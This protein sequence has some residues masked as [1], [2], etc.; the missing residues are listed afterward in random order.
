MA[1]ITEVRIKNFVNIENE[2]VF[3]ELKQ[4]NM[5][6]GLFGTGKFFND[7]DGVRTKHES[8]ATYGP[9]L[10]SQNKEILSPK[11]R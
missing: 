6:A 1:Q 2:I 9:L 7:E 11:L 8:R 10:P 3:D 4:Q 5:L